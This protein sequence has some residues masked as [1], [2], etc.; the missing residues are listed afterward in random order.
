MALSRSGTARGQI[1]R[2]ISFKLTGREIVL[3]TPITEDKIRAL[4]VGDVVLVSGKVYTGRDEVHKYPLA[5]RSAGDSSGQRLARR[6]ALSLRS[7]DAEAGR[8]LGGASGRPH[9][10]H[11]REPYQADLIRRFDPRRDG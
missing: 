1:G 3:E 5:S 6:P 2:G 7:G 9:N 4:K 11:P 10:F 8:A